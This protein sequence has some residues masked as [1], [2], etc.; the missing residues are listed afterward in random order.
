[1][2]KVVGIL[3]LIG[4][5]AACNQTMLGIG[6]GVKN[7]VS[8]PYTAVKSVFTNS[9]FK[10]KKKETLEDLEKKKKESHEIR[11]C[12]DED[13]KTIAT[14]DMENFR[15]I[16]SLL[17]E[18]SCE[19]KAWGS[20][21]KDICSC[22]KLCP[23]NFTIFRRSEVKRTQDY[24]IVDNDLCFRNESIGQYEMTNGY[25]WGHARLASQFNRLAFFEPKT[26]APHDIKSEDPEEQK[27]AIAYYKKLI[28]KVV[29]NKATTIPGF[30]N[31][32]EFSDHPALQSYLGDKMALT[33]ADNAMTY[34]GLRVGLGSEP[35]PV[36][37]YKNTLKEIKEFI[38]MGVQPSIVFTKSGQP[39]ETHTVTASH[40]KV[41]PGIGEV[42]C[43]RDNNR[44]SFSNYNCNNYLVL[45]DK[46]KLS[47]PSWGDIGK[48]EIA[49]NEKP[50]M[51]AQSQSLLK[52]CRKDKDCVN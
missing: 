24:C 22:E 44:S 4:F 37:E 47:Y 15:E 20:C 9:A 39:F 7:F 34:Q 27:R 18:Q 35:R 30:K 25:C 28:D 16:A 48:I 52:R 11:Y 26:K 36:D 51:L 2:N 46:G 45:D 21:P 42:I 31:L 5:L 49:H 32:A 13:G 14:D 3:F 33:W 10:D 1:M 6:A 40:V 8:A 29:S 38:S 41:K 17:Q 43:L 19:C 12:V 50:D 23:D